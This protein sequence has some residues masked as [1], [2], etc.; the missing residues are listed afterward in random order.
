MNVY[1]KRL[2]ISYLTLYFVFSPYIPILYAADPVDFSAPSAEGR[3]L[4]EQMLGEGLGTIQNGSIKSNGIENKEL[5]KPANQ[6]LIEEIK[7]EI[8]KVKDDLSNDIFNVKVK[9][10]YSD[11]ETKTGTANNISEYQHLAGADAFQMINQDI[12][13]IR[14]DGSIDRKSDIQ[15]F[16]DGYYRAATRFN[17][18]EFM[19]N[20]EKESGNEYITE[21]KIVIREHECE[22]W[23]ENR[24]V[25]YANKHW[26]IE[27]VFD[28]N[29]AIYTN[30]FLWSE[31]N[32]PEECLPLVGDPE[33]LFENG[34]VMVSYRISERSALNSFTLADPAESHGTFSF[35]YSFR[36]E[37]TKEGINANESGNI[38]TNIYNIVN[39]TVDVCQ[40]QREECRNVCDDDYLDCRDTCDVAIEPCRDTCDTNSF[41]C[42]TG[43]DDAESNCLANCGLPITVQNCENAYK[44]ALVDAEAWYNSC[45]SDPDFIFRGHCLELYEDIKINKKNDYD[46]CLAGIDGLSKWLCSHCSKERM[47]CDNECYEALADCQ[48]DCSKIDNI[49]KDDCLS[50]RQTCYTECDNAPCKP[51][52]TEGLQGTLYESGNIVITLSCTQNCGDYDP[53]TDC[54]DCSDICTMQMYDKI[55]NKY[56][57]STEIKY[58]PFRITEIV[59]YDD[60]PPES[61]EYVMTMK[62]LS[63][64]ESGSLD[65][66]YNGKT[67]Q[68]KEDNCWIQRGSNPYVGIPVLDEDDPDNMVDTIDDQ[69]VDPGDDNNRYKNLCE[70]TQ[71]MWS[72]P[73]QA[74]NYDINECVPYENDDT[75]ILKKISG[76]HY[77]YE[78]TDI[79]ETVT[80]V[81]G[82]TTYNCGENFSVRCVGEECAD[83][84]TE[85]SGKDLGD[86]VEEITT[87]S[88]I[89]YAA[90][91]IDDSGDLEVFKGKEYTC[92]DW[93]LALA[94]NCCDKHLASAGIS[95]IEFAIL[96]KQ[97]WD[98][99]KKLDAVEKLKNMKAVT[100]TKEAWVNATTC[101]KDAMAKAWSTVTKPITSAY[102]EATG[103]TV[104]TAEVSA[105]ESGAADPGAI[106]A[107]AE[108]ICQKFYE[109]SYKFISQTMGEGVANNIFTVSSG[110]AGNKYTL[111]S[112]EQTL[113]N[114]TTPELASSFMNA[115]Q[116]IWYI[117][118]IYTVYRLL[119]MIFCHCEKS[120]ITLSFNRQGKMCY[121]T[122]SQKKKRMYTTIYKK[123]YWCCFNSLLS[124]LISEQ[125][126]DQLGI[127]KKTAK[128]R[129]LTEEE[130]ERIDFEKMDFTEWYVAFNATVINRLN[131]SSVDA[132][133]F[134]GTGGDKAELDAKLIQQKLDEMTNGI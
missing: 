56:T 120:E 117:Y 39:Q 5:D 59:T 50:T 29:P 40:E 106:T 94:P 20:C 60:P 118:V 107:A 112:A 49:C 17:G 64:P 37:N 51:E 6:T 92:K 24:S 33:A 2:L 35:A 14:V 108:T 36:Y 52:E 109:Y 21:K 67:I 116:I 105:L 70:R 11:L 27:P 66:E 84:E 124:R 91:P 9:D 73:D 85:S 41:P 100:V 46:S 122:K 62:C 55:N 76:T 18:A 7:K 98:I 97:A 3:A 80:G 30:T 101:V 90:D 23:Q 114:F 71:E 113:G 78:C 131:T 8:G 38:T 47:S 111:N 32:D 22:K 26:Q 53:E 82:T 104:V 133:Y 28:V 15:E 57:A 79:Y 4:A 81:Q 95:W 119:I 61:C 103:K 10:H 44:Q 88:S 115:L 42:L 43:C 13:G 89:S 16:K 65:F 96:T 58:K 74:S 130:L 125:A 83:V 12:K 48:D 34:C 87:M 1:L 63:Y 45:T 121:K 86:A 110:E 132:A 19:E 31:W 123:Q 102:A 69:I 128:C 75:C 134:D 77:Y 25:Y 127:D 54:D 99:S 93:K 72:C 68:L 126:Y 129:G